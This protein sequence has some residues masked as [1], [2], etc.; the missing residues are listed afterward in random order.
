MTFT[1][2][3]W[4]FTT[5]VGLTLI[6]IALL[7]LGQPDA[8]LPGGLRWLILAAA[9]TVTAAFLRFRDPPPF[10]FYLLLLLVGAIAA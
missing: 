6:G 10:V 2:R 1:V 4:P 5:Y 7:G 9:L 3:G 8:G